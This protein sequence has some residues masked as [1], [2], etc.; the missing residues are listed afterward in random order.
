[1]N[2]HTYKVLLRKEPEGGFTVFVPALEGCITYGETLEE[3]QK[4]A[5]E[6]VELYLESLEEDKKT[7]PIETQL[8]EYNLQVTHG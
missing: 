5:R 4:N 7:F 8:L 6:A 1:M 2:T 3:A